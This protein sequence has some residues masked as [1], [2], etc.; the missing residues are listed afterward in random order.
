MMTAIVRG[1]LMVFALA[2]LAAPVHAAEKTASHHIVIQ[3]SQNDP[4]RTNLT[5]NNTSSAIKYYRGKGESAEVEIVAYGPGLNMLREDKSPVKDRIKELKASDIG[6]QV[7]FSGCH[8][9]QMSMEKQEGPPIPIIP[10][11]TIVPAGVVRLT[12]L[13]EQGWSYIRP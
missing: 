10:E 11:A 6:D 4:E 3:V 1:I 12:Q 2:L 5:L 7:K 9:T 13:E 8:N